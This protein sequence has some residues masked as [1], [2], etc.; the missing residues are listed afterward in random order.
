MTQI[1]FHVISQWV[2]YPWIDANS[3]ITNETACSKCSEYVYSSDNTFTETVSTQFNWVCDDSTIPIDSIST[4]IFMC[5][6]FFGAQG[7]G[8]LSG[9]FSIW[10]STLRVQ[11]RQID[12]F[13]P[14]KIKCRR[15]TELRMSWMVSNCR[16]VAF[17]S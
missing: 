7:F 2:Y 5:G 9:T 4:C 10:Y 12:A 11:L 17:L 3:L 13:Y 6:L 14:L 1:N 8:I 15:G 16:G